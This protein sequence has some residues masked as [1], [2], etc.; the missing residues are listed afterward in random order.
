VQP[1][2]VGRRGPP[3]LLSLLVSAMTQVPGL[4]R[5]PLVSS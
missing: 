4:P 2:T 1:L 3:V 5:Y